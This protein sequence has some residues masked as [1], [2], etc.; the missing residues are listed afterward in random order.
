L[1]LGSRVRSSSNASILRDY[2]RSPSETLS[3]AAI[4]LILI[5]EINKK[6]G[7]LSNRKSLL[8]GFIIRVNLEKKEDDYYVIF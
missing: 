5:E 8:T 6:M 2:A 3:R 7:E 4:S 1:P